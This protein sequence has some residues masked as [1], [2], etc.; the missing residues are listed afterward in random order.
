MDNR[1]RSVLLDG[2]ATAVVAVVYV[3][4]AGGANHVNRDGYYLE[5]Q[6]A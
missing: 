3:G 5:P 6:R 1:T 2:L 4:N